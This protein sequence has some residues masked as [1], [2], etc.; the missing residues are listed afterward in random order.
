[1]SKRW[2]NDDANRG[3]LSKKHRLAS[4]KFDIFVDP[5]KLGGGL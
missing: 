1:M 5:A 3:M 2:R 4:D